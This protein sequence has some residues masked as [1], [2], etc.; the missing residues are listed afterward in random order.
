MDCACSSSDDL[1]LINLGMWHFV[2]SDCGAR[3]TCSNGACVCDPG[4]FGSRCQLSSIVTPCSDFSCQNG[5][6][7][8]VNAD[9][10]PMCDCASARTSE[11]M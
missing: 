2:I 4:Y 5:G 11:G 8:E 9:N 1:K 6:V 3:G 7:C 10:E